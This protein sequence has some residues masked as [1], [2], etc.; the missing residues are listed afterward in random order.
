MNFS[1]GSIFALRVPSLGALLGGSGGCWGVVGLLGTAMR[2]RRERRDR[3]ALTPRTT[4]R[5]RLGCFWVWARCGWAVGVVKPRRPVGRPAGRS[6]LCLVGAP[7]VGVGRVWA[8][9]RGSAA[10]FSGESLV[11]RGASGRG[12]R[13][14]LFRPSRRGWAFSPWVA[15]GCPAGRLRGASGCAL[16][17][18]WAALGRPAGRLFGAVGSRGRRGRRSGWTSGLGVAVSAAGRGRRN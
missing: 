17:R 1:A 6:G 3:D 12:M 15:P 9:G 2:R 13:A 10:A 4:C 11:S 16:W 7:C 8:G 18:C 14:G 5:W